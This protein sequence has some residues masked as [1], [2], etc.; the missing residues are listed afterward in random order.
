[1]YLLRSKGA[2][3]IMRDGEGVA[4]VVGNSWVLFDSLPSNTQP[5]GDGDVEVKEAVS[6]DAYDLAP[7]YVPPPKAAKQAAV[8]ASDEAAPEK[9]KKR[10]PRVR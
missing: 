5:P 8:N 9:P 6:G 4:R 2:Q 3:L 10:K 7:A 1:M